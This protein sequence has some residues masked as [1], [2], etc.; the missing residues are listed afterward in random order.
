MLC[1]NHTRRTLST[2]RML[3]DERV[4]EQRLKGLQESLRELEDM[5]AE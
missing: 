5:M 2:H 1:L 3:R 4:E